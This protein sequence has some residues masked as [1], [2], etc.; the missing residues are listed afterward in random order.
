MTTRR[1]FLVV[2]LALFVACKS[3]G[4]RCAHCGMKIDETSAF[5][6][7]LEEN[8]ARE[9]F[10]TPRCA[11][12]EWKA[13]GGKGTVIVQDYYERVSQDGTKLRFVIGSDIIGPM[14]PEIV[15]V[16]AAR[17]PKLVKDHG[18]KDYAL[19]E[20]TFELLGQ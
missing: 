9:S 5:H 11:L 4:K 7:E 6:A 13:R 1:Q 17:A 3:E 2:P 12:S 19:G 10:D 20:L 14:G 16:D 15:P 8:G 18:G